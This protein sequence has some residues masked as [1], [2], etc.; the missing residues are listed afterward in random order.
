MKNSCIVLGDQHQN[1]LEGLRGL[2]ETLFEGVVMVA[3]RQSLFEALDKIK[4]NLAIV[5]WSLLGQGKFGASSELNKRFPEIKYIVLSDYTEPSVVED[6]M[7][8]G[9]SAFVLKQYA[10]IDL[11]DAITS[12]QEGKT[13]ISPTVNTKR[14]SQEH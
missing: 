6:A 2:L 4:P 14:D 10:G 9:A 8:A 11:F 12:I 1:I 13:Y 7:S 5:D 3:D